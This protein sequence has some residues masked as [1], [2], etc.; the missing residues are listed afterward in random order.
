ML[1]HKP[2][3]SICIHRPALVTRPRHFLLQLGPVLSHD[4]DEHTVFAITRARCPLCD[5]NRPRVAPGS[6]C[7]T[8]NGRNDGC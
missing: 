8:A 2:T 7:N 6:R 5:N 3:Q 4:A 1:E